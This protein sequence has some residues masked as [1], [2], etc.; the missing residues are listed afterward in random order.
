MRQVTKDDCIP[1]AFLYFTGMTEHQARRVHFETWEQ[2]YKAG[3][4]YEVGKRTTERDKGYG[5]RDDLLVVFLRKGSG[6]GDT[7]YLPIECFKIYDK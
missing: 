6:N 3:H 1:G 7:F 2:H 4:Y 5:Y